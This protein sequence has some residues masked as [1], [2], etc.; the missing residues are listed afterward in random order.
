M[1]A[2]LGE[3]VR[4]RRVIATEAL[5]RAELAE[6]TREDEARA[7]VSEERLRIA[8]DVQGTVAH[9]ISIIN[10]RSG[11]TAHILDTS[12]ACSTTTPTAAPRAQGSAR[13]ARVGSAVYRILQESITNV[14]R[15]VGPTRVTVELEYGAGAVRIIASRVV[16]VCTRNAAR[17][18]MAAAVWSEHSAIPASS[19]GT[20]PGSR[21]NPRLV[22]LADRHSLRLER[23]HTAH[24]HDVIRPDDLVVVVCDNAYE[25][26][27]DASVHWSV[28]DPGPVDTDEIFEDVLAQLAH[29]VSRLVTMV[30]AS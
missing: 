9:A 21:L 8:R 29:R 12:S 17:S 2:A 20:H 7:R 18:P 27:G 14:I 30:S 22:A 6:R 15:H 16:F 24:V 13:S 5:K 10:V 23:D 11:V 28:P 26:M 1:S 3:S 4:S 19:A 25:E